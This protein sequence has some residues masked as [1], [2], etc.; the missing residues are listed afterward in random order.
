[1]QYL[2]RM[3]LDWLDF[4]PLFCCYCCYFVIRLL[5]Y[6]IQIFNSIEIF[7]EVYMEE[8]SVIKPCRTMLIANS[9]RLL[10]LKDLRLTGYRF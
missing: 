9:N 2:V 5:S 7:D 1:M 10:G 8:F 3:I 4:P 6:F